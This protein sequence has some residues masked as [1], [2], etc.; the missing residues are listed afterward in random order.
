MSDLLGLIDAIAR[1]Q[2]AVKRAGS[3]VLGVHGGPPGLHELS[4][5]LGLDGVLRVEPGGEPVEREDR[6]GVEEERAFDDPV[7]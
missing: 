6:V 7:A 3:V 2:L 1:A 4:V 5:F